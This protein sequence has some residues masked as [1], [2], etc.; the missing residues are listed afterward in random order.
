M[1]KKTKTIKLDSKKIANEKTRNDNLIN[2]ASKIGIAGKARNPE[3]VFSTPKNLN[4][5]QLDNIY[6]GDGFGKKIVDVYANTMTREWFKI[7]GDPDDLLLNYTNNIKTKLSFNEAIKWS[8]LYGASVIVMLIDDGTGDLEQPVNTKAIRSVEGLRVIDRTQ[9]S[10]ATQDDLYTDATNKKYGTIEIYTISPPQSTKV[11]KG[12]ASALSATSYRVHETRILRFDGEI[13]P[14][15]LMIENGY[16]GFSVLISVYNYLRNLAQS[17]EVSSE[18]LH[19]Y[20]ISVIS[21]K[22]LSNILSRPDGEE[23]VK[24]RVEVINYCKSVINSIIMDSDGEQYDK[25]TT[26]LSGLPDL[27]DRFGLA[28]AAVAG[29]PYMVLMGDSASGLNASGD[30]DLRSWYDLIANE[31]HEIMTVQLNKL[32]SYI[33]ASSD[34]PLKGKTLNDLDIVYN[35]LWQIDDAAMIDMRNKQAETDQIYL[36]NGVAM[37]EEIGVSRFGGDSYSFET[38]IDTER[39]TTPF[40]SPDE[41]ETPPA[42]DEP[43]PEPEN[44]E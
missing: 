17:Y 14:P 2:V 33:L 19:D 6:L 15:R 38:T 42:D 31:Q 37:P 28:L 44:D 4:Y 1:N 3:S 11:T 35:P 13:A 40:E 23:A 9:L 39:V 26:S 29:I 12:I 21:I 25:I 24:Q 36:Q 32:L 10:V 16:F 30:S 22:N 5:V 18:I 20:V 8:R 43:A 27:I 41:D 34:N 7:S